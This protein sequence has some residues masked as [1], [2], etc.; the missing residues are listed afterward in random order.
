[1]AEIK[2][3][4][5]SEYQKSLN[6]GS[7]T[8]Q[9]AQRRNNV[10]NS[11][12]ANVET[13]RNYNKGLGLFSSSVD[14]QGSQLGV[15]LKEASL[16]AYLD[17][18]A[19]YVA[20]E[21]NLSQFTQVIT[22]K[23]KV[24]KGT[25]QVVLPMIGQQNPR[26]GAQASKTHTIPVSTPSGTVNLNSALV[27]GTIF[28]I[29]TINGATT[30]IVDDRKGK[31]LSEGGVL[32]VGT[33]DYNTGAIAYETVATPVA[34]DKFVISYSQDVRVVT[35]ATQNKRIKPRQGNFLINAQVNAFEYEFDV[36]SDALNAKTIG[37]T[38]LG[39]DMAQAVK[40]EHL[41]WI[42]N[43]LTRNIV[44]NYQ[45]NT[46]T[47]DLSAFSVNA[48]M[49]DSL[50][51]VFNSSMTSVDTALA[52]RTWKVVAAT[53]YLVGTGLGDLFQS[54]KAD[55]HWVPNN[56]GFI[57]GLIGFYKGRAVLRHN[58]V[59]EWDG[60]AIHKTPDG[61]LAPVGLGILLPAT[62]L[63]LVGNFAGTHEI[64][65]G[66]YSAEGVSTVTTEL[67]QKFTVKMPTDWVH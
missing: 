15:T 39:E 63:P 52:K 6:I 25:N 22:Y 23:D 60:Y 35:D 12:M 53:A 36:I 42:N 54:M 17:S 9:I 29:A 30:T 67:V 49:Y 50:I 32:K 8:Q 64:A 51:R 13:I 46:L 47:I 56:T 38:S 5:S 40:D 55:E 58:E 45:H 31:L 62:D 48:G 27:P 61:E 33:V 28:I 24:T 20:I 59:G 44:N 18:F 3:F 65:G 11:I 37:G 2:F 21:A 14:M 1:M 16:K 4:S 19:G 57:N 43:E 41:M 66:I 26:S 34:N 7:P 10:Y